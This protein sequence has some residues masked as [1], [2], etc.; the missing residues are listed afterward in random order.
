MRQLA[1]DGMFSVKEVAC[2]FDVTYPI[3]Y[4]A[5]TGKSFKHL[6]GSVKMRAKL[7]IK[8]QDEIVAKYA[9]GTVSHQTLATEY[10]VSYGTIGNI[11]RSHGR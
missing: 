4:N 9:T 8:Q 10:G 3:A 2:M 6:D 1:K 11:V 5:I 7:T